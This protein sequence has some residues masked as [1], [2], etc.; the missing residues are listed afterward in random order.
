[1]DEMGI[2]SSIESYWD[3]ATGVLCQLG[4]SISGEIL[5]E[6]LSMSIQFLII[7]TNVWTAPAGLLGVEWPIW[8]IAFATIAVGTVGVLLLR[9]H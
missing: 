5:E 7:E 8:I 2:N 6:S 3:Q 1:M 4:M 9:R